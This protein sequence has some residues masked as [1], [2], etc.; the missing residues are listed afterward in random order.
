M[1]RTLKRETARPP[2]SDHEAQQARF[3][4]WRAEF[5][6]ERPHEA[7]EMKTPVSV[8]TASAR[9]L[10][11]QLPEP[12]YPGHF[13]VRLVSKSSMFRLHHRPIFISEAL[14]GEYIGLEE[15]GDGVW[16][17][18]FFDVLLGRLSERDYKVRG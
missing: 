17:V 15:T 12:C 3:D 5:N 8:Y 9:P 7:L 14:I 18:Y 1:H 10:P 2:E 6:Q 16:S 13:L 4:T 11:S